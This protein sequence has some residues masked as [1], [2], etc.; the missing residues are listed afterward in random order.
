MAGMFYSLQEAAERLGKTQDELRGIVNAGKLREFRDGPN[1]LFKVEEVEALMSEAG[2][3]GVQEAPELQAPPPQPPL[4]EAPPPQAPELEIPEAEIPLELDIPQAEAPA[5]QVFDAPAPELDIPI[6]PDAFQAETPQPQAPEPVAPELEIPSEL[7]APEIDMAEL[8]IPETTAPE[9]EIPSELEAPEM[10]ISE[11]EVPELDVPIAQETPAGTS[12]ILLAPE[13][14]AP[15]APSEL[16]NADTAITGEGVNVLGETDKD[17]AIT[18]DTLGETVGS[19][20]LASTGTT[21]E[22]SLEEIEGDV[23]LDSFGSGSGLLDL[24]LQADDTSLGGILDEI[25]TAE[26]EAVEAADPG[27]VA[28][29]AAEVEQIDELVTPQADLAMAGLAQARFE[30]APDKASNILG[31][32]LILPCA[33]LIYTTAVA[34]SGLTGVAP[35]ILTPIKGFLWYIMGGLFVLALVV[36]VWAFM[37]DQESAPAAERSKKAKKAKK[38]KKPKKTKKPKKAKK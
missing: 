33:L 28:D 25:Y 17:Y 1:L 13:T 23:N 36:S 14:G 35:S 38:P 4:P 26:D 27:T 16:T 7:E 11:L 15:V 3:M 19:L 37:P 2:V 18:D 20:G 21:P 9:L 10:D 29:V 34:V 31:A 22:A 24:S 5:P 32:M 12:E 30:P 6:E 8:E